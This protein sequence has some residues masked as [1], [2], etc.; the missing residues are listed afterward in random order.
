[1]Y[2][3]LIFYFVFQRLLLALLSK[4]NVFAI[5][6]FFIIIYI[7][8]WEILPL[9][10]SVIRRFSQI[11]PLFVCLAEAKL[12]LKPNYVGYTRLSKVV[13]SVTSKNRS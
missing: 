12:R 3:G 8:M 7:Y 9:L 6:F 5:R 13:I 4:C 2:F 1:M 11:F 10:R